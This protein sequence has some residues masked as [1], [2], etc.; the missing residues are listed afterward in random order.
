M[1]AW[2]WD[3][4]L[5]GHGVSKVLLV[6]D[7]ERK[8]VG[9]MCR[10]EAQRP[11]NHCCYR[12]AEHTTQGVE[13]RPVEGMETLGLVQA[14]RVQEQGGCALNTLDSDRRTEKGAE[15]SETYQLGAR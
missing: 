3:P 10:M 12:T 1:S 6:S 15:V 5:G 14:G 7:G 2:C 13:N 8:R 4:H 11:H 9:E